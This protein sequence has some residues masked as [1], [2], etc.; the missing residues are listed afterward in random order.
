MKWMLFFFLFVLLSRNYILYL[1]DYK[2][3]RPFN[4]VI[5]T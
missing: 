3:Y 4:T 5:R 2:E 1:L